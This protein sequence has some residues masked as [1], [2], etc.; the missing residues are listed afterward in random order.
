ML[1]ADYNLPQFG[2]GGSG[3][4]KGWGRRGAGD[5][6]GLRSCIRELGPY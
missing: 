3:G 1:H 4:F 6:R 2:G 5:E